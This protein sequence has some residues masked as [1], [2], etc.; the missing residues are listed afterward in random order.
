MDEDTTNIPEIIIS[1]PEPPPPKKKQK[2]RKKEDV[3]N[4]SWFNKGQSGNPAG[5]PRKGLSLTD[6]LKEMGDTPVVVIDSTTGVQRSIPRKQRLAE[7]AWEEAITHKDFKFVKFIYERLDGLPYMMEPEANKRNDNDIDFGRFK[8]QGKLFDEQLQ[9]L[10]SKKRKMYMLCGRRSGK[11]FAIAAKMVDMALTHTSG[12]VYYITK[13]FAQA[14]KNIWNYLIDLLDLSGVPYK[15][16]S[17]EGVIEVSTGCSLGISGSDTIDQVD[18][19]RGNKYLGAFIDEVQSI[20]YAGYLVQDIIGPA[21]RD[22]SD[23]QLILSGTPS[24]AEGTKWEEWWKTSNP[25]ILKLHWTMER[26]IHIPETERS[27]EKIKADENLTDDSP[28]FQREYL[29]EFVY[30]KEARVYIPT[31]RNYYQFSQFEDW[32]KMHRCTDFV[33]PTDQWDERKPAHTLQDIHFTGGLDYGFSDA[34]G[35]VIVAYSDSS[36]ERWILY[37]YKQNHTGVAEVA[38]AVRQ[39]L[40]ALYKSIPLFKTAVDSEDFLIYADYGGGGAKISADLRTTYALPIVN[41]IKQNKDLAI[42][43]LQE[44]VRIGRLR[45]LK[46]GPFDTETNSILWKR[47]EDEHIIREIDDDAFHPDVA[48]AL[49]YAMRPIWKYANPQEDTK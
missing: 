27:F 8:V 25:D 33:A 22:Y 15:A 30:D 38:A 1:L 36:P 16:R 29:G 31:E 19:L 7:V 23:S 14:H 40:D 13:T 17:A 9:L 39:G 5:R 24:R 35:F 20:K 2:P 28:R 18:K 49:L 45:M 37:E 46:G 41:A 42:D 44:D 3:L 11:T 34:D 32:V 10:L 21:L 4:P 43:M 6:F 47:D 48:D 12:S 26:N